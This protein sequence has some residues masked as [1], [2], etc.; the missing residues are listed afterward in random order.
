M[1]LSGVYLKRT[2][3]NTQWYDA[4]NHVSI[5][6]TRE[7]T[8]FS[9]Q[10][11]ERLFYPSIPCKNCST[12]YIKYEQEIFMLIFFFVQFTF[13]LIFPQKCF[14]EAL[15][16]LFYAGVFSFAEEREHF[17]ID[18]FGS[19]KIL[20]C[21]LE[22]LNGRLFYHYKSIIFQGPTHMCHNQLNNIIN[23]KVNIPN[24]ST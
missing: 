1:V 3:Y 13:Y 7:V 16:F 15:S 17:S 4:L 12:C 5:I 21:H 22:F 6:H 20:C 9:F 8:L 19:V 18:S 14:I 2:I 24:E 23:N 11:F 10:H